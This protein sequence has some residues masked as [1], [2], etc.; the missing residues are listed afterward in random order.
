MLMLKFDVI[1]EVRDCEEPSDELTRNVHVT[2]TPNIDT[3][4]RKVAAANFSAVSYVMNTPSF[5]TRFARRRTTQRIWKE[6][7][8]WRLLTSLSKR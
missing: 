4:V 6:N 1:E 5:V 3:F 2:S 7:G 8:S